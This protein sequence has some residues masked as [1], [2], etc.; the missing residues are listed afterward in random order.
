MTWEEN[1]VQE[2]T[3]PMD[4]RP[5][6]PDGVKHQEKKNTL[7]CQTGGGVF[8]GE[9]GAIGRSPEEAEIIRHTVGSSLA[10][11]HKKSPVGLS[12]FQFYQESMILDKCH[13]S[14]FN[15]SFPAL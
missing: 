10:G 14:D 11:L 6:G 2:K 9:E 12:L 3:D 15:D 1:V 5:D 8:G 7:A 13:S 4:Q